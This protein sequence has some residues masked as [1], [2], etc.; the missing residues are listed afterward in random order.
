MRDEVLS[1][2]RCEVDGSSTDGHSSGAGRGTRLST[3][4]EPAT[5][6]SNRKGPYRR[7]GTLYAVEVCWISNGAVTCRT[8]RVR[9][10]NESRA[11]RIGC[12][13]ARKVLRR[14]RVTRIEAVDVEPI[15]RGDGHA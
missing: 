1:R 3:P 5:P 12:R 4:D 14:R 11:A 7:Q 10:V 8:Y 15:G 2:W 13:R 6:P 9:A